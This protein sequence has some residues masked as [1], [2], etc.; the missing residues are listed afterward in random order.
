M[1]VTFFFLNTIVMCTF[2]SNIYIYI[3][4]Y[5]G[6]G[7]MNGEYLK[8]LTGKAI[9]MYGNIRANNQCWKS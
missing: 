7:V 3:L 4:Y 6:G 2:Y 8:M 5:R 1:M 9:N